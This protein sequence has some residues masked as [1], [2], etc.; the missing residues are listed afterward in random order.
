MSKDKPGFEAIVDWGIDTLNRRIYFG[1][2][3]DQD[4][5]GGAIS[6]E[7]VE[8]A[9]RALHKLSADS[10]RPIEIHMSSGGGSSVDML[11]LHDEILACPCKVIFIGGGMISSSATWIMAC[12]DERFLHTNT[13]VLLHDG[14]DTSQADRHT[15]YLI[16][17]KESEDHMNLLYK[18]YADNSH[19]PFDFY[20]DVCQ[21]DLWITAEE[22]IM[23]GL[24]DKLVEPKKRGNLRRGRS[25]LKNVADKK[26]IN[27]FVKD[28]YKRIRRHKIP[29]F[30]LSTPVDEFDPKVT[31][32]EPTIPAD[33]GAEKK[34]GG[35]LH[36]PST[37]VNPPSS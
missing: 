30:E 24:A 3:G 32:G 14:S 11:R 17:A 23:L 36:P 25:G 26:D 6:W 34:A 33:D 27:K 37:V 18:I 4:S 5:D 31:V 16:G 22:T 9:I 13:T 15:D 8:L 12:C 28:I 2:D 20:A 21:R 19:M 35:L 29:K 10:N 1:I 7:S